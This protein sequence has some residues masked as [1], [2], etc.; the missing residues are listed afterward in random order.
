M[1]SPLPF[2]IHERRLQSW[3]SN[4]PMVGE[5]THSHLHFVLALGTDTSTGLCLQCQINNP[6]PHQ[7]PKL[8]SNPECLL[9][10]CWLAATLSR[11]RKCAFSPVEDT[12]HIFLL[13]PKCVCNLVFLSRYMRP[14]GPWQRLRRCPRATAVAVYIYDLFPGT[15]TGLASHSQAPSHQYKKRRKDKRKTPLSSPE[16]K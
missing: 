1:A 9:G 6:N 11:F 10:D 13:Y 12:G 4:G 15:S 7:K 8:V 3:R 16:K 14:E 5:R 2:V